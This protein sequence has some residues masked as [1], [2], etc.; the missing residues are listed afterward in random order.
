VT[1][2]GGTVL[3][4]MDDTAGTIH[5][6]SLVSGNFVDNGT[7]VYASA[8]AVF[9]TVSGSTVKLY[10]R[11]SAGS[12]ID[13]LT[14][15]S[16]FNATIT[17]SVAT[18]ITAPTNEV[19]RGIAA[20]PIAGTTPTP[21]T[22]T[23]P[24]PGATATRTVT[25]T[26]TATATPTATPTPTATTT[27]LPAP[28]TVGNIVVYRVGDGGASL[29]NTGN[30]VFL[31]EFQPNGTHVQTIGLPAT[32]S[33]PNHQLVASGTA[34]SEGQMTTSADGR[35]L[36]LTG[37]ASDIPAA[38]SLSSSASA[39]VSRAIA[40][41]KFDGTI[42]TSTA[43]NDFDD[44]D[45]PR[46]ATSTDGTS[47]WMCGNSGGVRFAN[48]GDTT[49]TQLTSDSVNN[50][51]IN[52]FANQL[53]VTSQK[54]TTRVAT[55]GG[56]PPP[57]TAPQ[58]TTN[59]PGFPGTDSPNA[60]FLADLDAGVAGL[61]TLYAADSASG[62]EKFS[63]VG[64][65]WTSNGTIGSGSDE[66]SGL[67]GTVNGSTVTLYATRKGGS[68]ATGGG[69]L[70]SLTDASG[71]NAAP[72]GTIT[73][74]ATA[75]TNQAFRGVAIA[76]SS[77]SGG[78]PS[79][80]VPPDKVTGKCE[81]GAAKNVAKLGS[82]VRKC[83]TKLADLALKGKPFDEEGCES[84]GPKSCRVKYDATTAKLT[85]K[86]TCPPCL[87][88]TAQG[89][90][91]DAVMSS[92]DTE[93]GTIYCGG[94]TAFGDDD[95]GFVPPDK[96]TGKCED[97]VAKLVGALATCVGSCQT[98]QAATLFKGGTFDLDACE[99]TGVKSCRGKFDVASGKL[100]KTPIC[101]SCL[102]PGARGT[103]ADGAAA[104]LGQL[105]PSIYCAGT[106]PLP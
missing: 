21:T 57:T 101:P 56:T 47:L 13:T 41:V 86:G 68:T 60:I 93:V 40:R 43:L 73:L 19:F 102:D 77:G 45:N 20:A 91:A 82:C 44:G 22:T 17:G 9:A 80:F 8:R 96:N 26:V 28:F 87:G 27:P 65:N 95:P 4:L 33:G 92:L 31:D 90:I 37:Y 25:P 10:V 66:Y 67:T 88:A 2:P 71:Y 23:T 49:S 104:F 24:A 6:W 7:I 99:A 36:I 97:G 42:D 16:G 14:D 51:Y 12:T 100:D 48:L 84:T 58:T 83:H 63:L 69:E 32:A 5:K 72:T 52:I 89:T 94:T 39:T 53:Y 38:S 76:P 70:V 105:K 30:P 50:R 64:G 81:D 15:A 85:Q 18:L 79:G 59:L 103:V 3:Y 34:Q 62:I 29:A 35:F 61:D 78:S 75:G 74:L 46:S 98:K 1:L 54:L 55:I 106:T 11:S